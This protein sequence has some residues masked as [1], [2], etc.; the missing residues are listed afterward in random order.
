MVGRN[1]RSV[2]NL[3]IERD[4]TKDQVVVFIFIFATVGLLV[5]A[6]VGSW[7]SGWMRVYLSS[8]STILEK[9]LTERIG[10]EGKKSI[11]SAGEYFVIGGFSR[12]TVWNLRNYFLGLDNGLGHRDGVL[13][14][15]R[16][17][18]TSGGV[19]HLI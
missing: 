11:H 19:F 6:M 4:S 14:S 10:Y 15:L 18:G 7:V 13:L 17:Y 2:A 12:L 5:W 1:G 3:G 8:M 9:R 16:R